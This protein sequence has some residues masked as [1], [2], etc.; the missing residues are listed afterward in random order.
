MLVINETAV[1]S[2]QFQGAYFDGSLEL[3]RELAISNDVNGALP[4]LSAIVRKMLPHDAL[5]ISCFDP[6][7]RLVVDASTADVPDM[8]VA[9]N[10]VFIEDLRTSPVGAVSHA[11]DRLIGAGYRSALGVSTHAPEPIVRVAFW[12]R[13]PLAFNRTQVPL[14]RRIA[15][16]LGLGTQF[17]TVGRTIPQT[18]TSGWNGATRSCSEP[19]NRRPWAPACVS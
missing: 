12:S 14:A 10:E 2:P 16:H 13:Q 19:L 7:G 5:R 4:R 11:T 3:L 18:T 1:D 6:G 9:G 8:T 15:Y 17:R